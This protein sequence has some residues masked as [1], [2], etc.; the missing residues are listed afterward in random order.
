MADKKVQVSMVSFG[1]PAPQPSRVLHAR[2]LSLTRAVGFVDESIGSTH[3]N[4][5]WADRLLSFK[6][7]PTLEEAKRIRMVVTGDRLSPAHSVLAVLLPEGCSLATAFAALQ[8]YMRQAQCRFT[9]VWMQSSC[10]DSSSSPHSALPALLRCSS[11]LMIPAETSSS[12]GSRVSD[13]LGLTVQP[14]MRAD[15]A[16]ASLADVQLV[17][18]VCIDKRE[19]FATLPQSGSF[20]K[21]AKEVGEEF[22]CWNDV[23]G[24]WDSSFRVRDLAVVARDLVLK[25]DLLPES[26]RRR[27]FQLSLA[28]PPEWWA[29]PITSAPLAGISR[30]LEGE[31]LPLQ[32]ILFGAAM[33]EGLTARQQDQVGQLLSTSLTMMEETDSTSADKAS[34]PPAAS[35]RRETAAPISTV[36]N[37]KV[38]NAA[39]A[40]MDQ[41]MVAHLHLRGKGLTAVDAM[42]AMHFIANSELKTSLHSHRKCQLSLD[43]NFLDGVSVGAVLQEKVFT[44]ASFAVNDIGNSV[45]GISDALAAFPDRLRSLNLGWNNIGSLGL[46][47]L[48]RGI[49]SHPTLTGL[50]LDGNPLTDCGVTQ[51]GLRA[52][53]AALEG[54]DTVLKSLSLS[55]T[56]LKGQTDGDAVG[57]LI[58]SS[59]SLRNFVISGNALASD[60][61]ASL[62]HATS[63][64]SLVSL[65]FS[66]CGMLE[67]AA[68]GSTRSAVT[69]LAETLKTC[70]QLRQLDLFGN[71]LESQDWSILLHA[72][73]QR[74]ESTSLELLSEL[75]E[76]LMPGENATERTVGHIRRK[77][78]ELSLEGEGEWTHPDVGEGHMRSGDVFAQ[79]GQAS[80]ALKEYRQAMSIWTSTIGATSPSCAALCG[81]IGKLMWESG[82]ERK[83][84]EALKRSLAL[85]VAAVGDG[86]PM[87]SP[88]LASLGIFLLDARRPKEA[89]P[90]LQAALELDEQV[91]GHN[92]PE[93]AA[94]LTNLA[95]LAQNLAEDEEALQL[96]RR[97]LR[98][99]ESATAS[100]T[101]LRIASVCSNLASALR[102]SGKVEEG[103]EVCRRAMA[104]L[105]AEL[106][107]LEDTRLVPTLLMT[108]TLLTEVAASQSRRRMKN[109][110]ARQAVD[111]DRAKH[112]T[113]VEETS[114]AS[115]LRM[116]NL[117]TAHYSE[118]QVEA[119]AIKKEVADLL[120]EA[121][122]ALRRAV[123]IEESDFG[124][125]LS[126]ESS[127][128]SPPPSHGI[129]LMKLAALQYE[130][131][132]VDVAEDNLARGREIAVTPEMAGSESELPVP[133]L[134]KT[135]VARAAALTACGRHAEAE[136]AVT[137]VMPTLLELYGKDK[138]VTRRAQ[139]TL[140]KARLGALQEKRDR[141]FR[142]WLRLQ[143]GADLS[144][145]SCLKRNK[146]SSGDDQGDAVIPAPVQLAQQSSDASDFVSSPLTD[147]FGSDTGDGLFSPLE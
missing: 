104:I 114:A 24:C 141:G 43:G 16:V 94:D 99:T 136:A 61:C 98:I 81:R 110:R 73:A 8:T 102:D 119:E 36:K 17:L 140:V 144:F 132:E 45:E 111:E 80:K 12:S 76:G 82:Q 83:A 3:A 116:V 49:R 57:E 97:A 139:R 108:A 42:T 78:G 21:V 124:G 118:R 92:H 20:K 121:E 52:L 70:T 109:L 93:V 103:L 72:A 6:K 31:P 145:M 51:G 100:P 142:R 4:F 11:A 127:C 50:V 33:L 74:P 128:V 62:A 130:M 146:K 68:D 91:Y 137:Q 86:H 138:S 13:I 2:L 7:F 134:A 122:S 54:P 105:E 115:K 26:L 123:R 90:F 28:S 106:G 59:H 101:S 147:D 84:E 5:L 27:L 47:L 125:G 25:D 38:P 10:C 77:S 1:A 56:G 44:H 40:S 14:W 58:A 41:G 29:D 107:S 143:S 117:Q 30:I 65:D 64:S 85:V 88:A 113:P 32:H 79:S 15:L 131:G 96:L 71:A 23:K 89:R 66:F 135:T 34:E 95:A 126:Q 67:E 75:A 48:S 19:V 9:H 87:V 22:G 63:T 112:E 18:H 60:G 37:E 129:L 133:Q 39:S 35:D 120:K 46:G 69:A 53:A 55:C